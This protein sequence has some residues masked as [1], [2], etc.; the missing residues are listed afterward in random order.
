MGGEPMSC[1]SGAPVPTPPPLPAVPAPTASWCMLA[2]PCSISCSGSP[3]SPGDG[4]LDAIACKATE[5]EQKIEFYNWQPCH[6]N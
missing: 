2:W 1:Q 5:A 4:P 3:R 6:V